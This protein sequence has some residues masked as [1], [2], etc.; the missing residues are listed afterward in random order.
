[1]PKGFLDLN[2]PSHKTLYQLHIEKII[3]LQNEIKSKFGRSVEI[4]LYVMTSPESL[5]QT[6][7][8]FIKH[9]FFGLSSKQ[10]FFFRQRYVKIILAHRSFTSTHLESRSLPC[11]TPSGEIIMDTKCSVVFSPDGHGGLFTA[12]KDAK[13]FEV[14]QVLPYSR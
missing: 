9:N 11:V 1:M 4:P 5:Q 2:L 10:V 3:R 7:Q 12:L 6:H 14:E 8:F 13:A